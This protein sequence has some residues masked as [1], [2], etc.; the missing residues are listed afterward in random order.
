MSTAFTAGNGSGRPAW[1]TSGTLARFG[2]DLAAEPA[3]VRARVRLTRGL[4]EDAA[5]RYGSTPFTAFLCHGVLMYLPDPD[6][7]L[8][9]I[10]RRRKLRSA[11]R[12]RAPVTLPPGDGGN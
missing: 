6:P 5:E 7:V 2:S 11:R 8:R 3:E 10:A 9:A 4:M 1:S 12:L